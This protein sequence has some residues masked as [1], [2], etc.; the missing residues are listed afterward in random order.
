VVVFG[1]VLMADVRLFKKSGCSHCVAAEEWLRQRGCDFEV[2]EIT[3]NV[4]VLRE[5]RE[6]SGGVGVPV[7]A[8]GK[9]LV[10]GFSPERYRDFL[11]SCRQT[12]RVDESEVAAQVP[13]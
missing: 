9:D 1:E 10:I 8:H 5:W 3:Q 13:E 7:L 2:L 6:L 12:M 4:Q 11:T